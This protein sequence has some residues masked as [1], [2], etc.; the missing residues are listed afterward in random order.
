MLWH[1]A[2]VK[3]PFFIENGAI[4]FYKAELGLHCCITGNQNGTGQ[5]ADSP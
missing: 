5:A 4:R 2:Y 1:R 3:I